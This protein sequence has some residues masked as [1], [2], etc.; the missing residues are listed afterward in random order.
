MQLHHMVTGAGAAL[1]TLKPIWSRRRVSA[2]V[3]V[4]LQRQRAADPPNAA[5]PEPEPAVTTG[6]CGVPLRVA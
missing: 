1:K 5:G 3:L 2:R 6:T 4:Q